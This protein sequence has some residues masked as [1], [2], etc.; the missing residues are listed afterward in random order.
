MRNSLVLFSL[1]LTS[2]TL[3]QFAQAAE[4]VS[5]VRE[6]MAVS[7]KPVSQASIQINQV[8]QTQVENIATGTKENVEKYN[9]SIGDGAT[10]AVEALPS[11]NKPGVCELKS[12]SITRE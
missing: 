1:V 7:M 2:L 4:C 9:L 5:L 11:Y 8:Q 12:L 3:S 6:V 10:A